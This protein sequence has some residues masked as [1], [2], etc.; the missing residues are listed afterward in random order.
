MTSATISNQYY[1]YAAIALSAV[2]GCN[3]SAK[4]DAV[5]QGT[6]TIDGELVSQG[7][8]TFHP[9]GT[10]PVAYGTILKDGTYALRVGRGKKNDRANKIYPGKY[11]ATVAVTVSSPASQDDEGGL[12]KPGPRLTDAKFSDKSTSVL[13]YEVESGRNIIN[14]SVDRAQ[15]PEGA[16]TEEAESEESAVENEEQAP[17]AQQE[18]EVA[19][20]PQEQPPANE[21]PSSEPAKEEPAQ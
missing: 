15:P 5:V 2:L 21:E 11:T 3:D 20:S 9:E 10:G 19:D 4:Q 7:I 17:T 18:T 14:I 12:P 16:E 13:K 1:A 6:V 8:V